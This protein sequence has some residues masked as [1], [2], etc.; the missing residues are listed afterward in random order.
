M[1]RRENMDWILLVGLENLEG[2][3]EVDGLESLPWSKPATIPFPIICKGFIV[4]DITRFQVKMYRNKYEIKCNKDLL[5]A[6]FWTWNLLSSLGKLRTLLSKFLRKGIRPVLE[7]IRFP[8][9]KFLNTWNTGMMI[10]FSVRT[11]YV[12]LAWT[13]H[14]LWIF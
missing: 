13:E 10:V 9:F 14:V 5:S 7:K 6:W 4:L 3:E 1:A 11:L 12:F 8:S 2:Y